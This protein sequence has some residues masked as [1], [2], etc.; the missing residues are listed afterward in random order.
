MGRAYILRDL[1]D[2][3]P[4]TMTDHVLTIL[5]IV[6]IQRQFSVLFDLSTLREKAFLRFWLANGAAMS[7]AMPPELIPLLST[8]RGTVLDIGPGSG[9]QLHRYTSS[10]VSAIYGAEPAIKLHPKLQMK[11]MDAGLG[12]KYHILGCGAEPRSL[13]PALAG[14]G[15]IG[16]GNTSEGIFDDIVSIRVLCGVPD[17]KETVEGLYELLKPGGR[18]IAYEH[19]V[20]PWK[21]EKGSTVARV[22]QWM[23]MWIGGWRFW[24]AGCNLDRDIGMVLREAGK[25]EDGPG[26]SRVEMKTLN[27]WSTILHI[28]GYLVK[29]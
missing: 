28:V 25:S 11:A 14:V 18:F 6:F 27:A 17:L 19:V 5:E 4:T 15:L 20:S 7:A 8:L 12:D 21:T 10:S 1:L 23:Y 3:D 26:W 22:L 9:E 2:L 29:N 16:E 24:M 13:I